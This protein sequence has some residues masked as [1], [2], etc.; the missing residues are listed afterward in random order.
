MSQPW[1]TYPQDSPG[2]GY[3][4]MI[5]PVCAGGGCSYL[6]PDTNIAVPSGTPIT[7]LLPG[8]V[9]AVDY[10]GT[11]NGGL[12]VTVQLDNA[13]NSLAKYVSYNFLGSANVQVGQHLSSG[14][15]LGTAGSPTG[16]NFAL[17]LGPSAHWGAVCPGC[18]GNPLTD[19]RILLR[20]ATSGTLPLSGSIGSN[21][22][23]STGGGTTS[24]SQCA[25][26]D[27]TCIVKEGMVAFFG[28]DF[29]TQSIIVLVAIV[30]GLIGVIVLVFG[31]GAQTE[32]PA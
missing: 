7:A 19:P 24:A 22:S 3:G 27:V 26:W 11:G 9:S 23:S 12:S 14:Q 8:I 13:L 31:H 10:N 29:F 17:G 21:L 6:K 5:D 20:E 1:Y 28:S 4:E 18:S 30:L 16:I 2:G 32:R 15:Q 25:P